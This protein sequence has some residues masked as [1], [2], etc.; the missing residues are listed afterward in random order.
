MIYIDRFSSALCHLTARIQTSVF[1]SRPIQYKRNTFPTANGSLKILFW[2]LEW[3]IFFFE[4]GGRAYVEK[5]SRKCVTQSYRATGLTICFYKDSESVHF[6]LEAFSLCHMWQTLLTV[7]MHCLATSLPPPAPLFWFYFFL[8]VFMNKTLIGLVVYAN[9]ND[10]R[11]TANTKI[12][13]TWKKKMIVA[14]NIA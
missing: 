5:S 2:Q 1:L 10:C 4:E 7:A 3:H 13:M 14:K 9:K 8:I 6:A 12:R 11:K